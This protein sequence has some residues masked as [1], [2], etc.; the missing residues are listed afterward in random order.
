MGNKIP[1]P[2][3]FGAVIVKDGEII[4]ADHSHVSELN[5]PSAHDSISA[6]RVA[7]KKLGAHN[8]EGCTMYCSHEPCFM[9]TAAAA[10]AKIERIVYA[11]PAMEN[12][13]FIYHSD[14]LSIEEFAAKIP[15]NLKVELIRIKQ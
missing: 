6:I 7:A 3:N 11:N 8:F 10:W 2:Y 12:K 14:E 13:D 15:R 5:D 9:C 4:A 1:P